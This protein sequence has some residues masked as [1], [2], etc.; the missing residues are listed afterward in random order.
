MANPLH[1]A[2]IHH[3]PPFVTAPGETDVLFIV[4]AV[5]V[6]LAVIGIGIF[7][8]KL[9][10]LPEQMAHRGQKIQFELVAVLALLALFTHNHAFWIAGLLLA[11]VP[12]P[13]FTT[14][15]SSM[16]RALERIADGA[17]PAAPPRAPAPGQT[18]PNVTA[19]D[20][21]QPTESREV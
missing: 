7:Y 14:P 6:L 1:P 8:F 16:A 15:L 4:M 21:D 12:L 3:L 10:A 11:F 5:F 13:D 18:V 19:P 17:G 20:A 2:A 9:H